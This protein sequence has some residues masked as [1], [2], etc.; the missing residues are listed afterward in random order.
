VII[1]SLSPNIFAGKQPNTLSSG[2]S[3]YQKRVQ[4]PQ[5][6]LEG[7]LKNEDGDTFSLSNLQNMP[8]SNTEY[9]QY[10]RDAISTTIDT[11]T[12]T[13]YVHYSQWSGS[14]IGNNVPDTTGTIV[15]KYNP[16][17]NTG[18]A[19][20]TQQSGKDSDNCTTITGVIT[21]DYNSRT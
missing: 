1:S 9:P 17:S 20:Y 8:E 14:D 21:V 19:A 2:S 7:V 3:T 12:N 16:D 15:A 5:D 11:D 10:S 13:G 4:L 18:V 6:N